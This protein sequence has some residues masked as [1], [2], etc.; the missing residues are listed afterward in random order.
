MAPSAEK[1]YTMAEVIKHNKTDDCWLVIGN[2]ATGECAIL[3]GVGVKYVIPTTPKAK[4]IYTKRDKQH[5]CYV[6]AGWY[7]GFAMLTVA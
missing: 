1:E 6:F 7:V 3:R 2:D 5:R 4:Y